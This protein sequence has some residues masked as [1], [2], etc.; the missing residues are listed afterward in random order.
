MTRTTAIAL[1]LSTSFLLV[2]AFVPRSPRFAT[3]AI[4][5]SQLSA[6]QR[7][8]LFARDDEMQTIDVAKTEPSKNAVN[9]DDSAALDKPEKEL[10]ETENLL[11]QVKDAGL[12]GVIS[13]AL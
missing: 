1:F 2:S 8:Q 12:A 4:V 13:Y 11:Q 6:R 3:R 9:G 10:S 7:S 5:T